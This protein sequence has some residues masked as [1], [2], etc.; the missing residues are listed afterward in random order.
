MVYYNSHKCD[1]AKIFNSR[2]EAEEFSKL[3]AGEF[4]EHIGTY[5]ID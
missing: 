4:M 5:I 3:G 2:I 1:I